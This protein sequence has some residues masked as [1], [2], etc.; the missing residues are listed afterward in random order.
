MTGGLRNV[1]THEKFRTSSAQLLAAE[2]AALPYVASSIMLPDLHMKPGMEAPS[3]FVVATRGRIIPQ[4]VSESIN[5]GMG[6]LVFDVAADDVDPASLQAILESI[7]RAGAVTKLK[8]T[9]YSWTPALLEAACRQGAAPLIDHYGL[10]AE[11]IDRIEDRGRAKPDDISRAAFEAAVPSFLRK[12]KLTRSEIGLNF[13][14]N[15]F[16][17]L[18]RVDGVVDLGA[19][20][21]VGVV[22]GKL[23]VMYHL[24]PGPLGS[25][26]SNLYAYRSKPQLHRK[27]GY[28]AFRQILHASKGWASYRQFAGVGSWMAVDADSEQGLA[29]AG[30]LDVIKNYGFAYRMATV[31]AIVDAVGSVLGVAQNDANLVIDLSHNML[32]SE[33]VGSETL[34]VSRHNCCRPVPGGL[35]IVSGN[36][37]ASSALTISP[38]DSAG[39]LGGFDHGVGFL[40]EEATTAGLTQEDV[41]GYETSRYYMTRGVDGVHR[42]DVQ[43]LL[44]RSV[45]DSAMSTLE[46]ERFASPVAYLRPLMTLKHKA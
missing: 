23:A 3:S 1:T 28:G 10:P 34:W 33:H 19:A 4:L 42:H 16:L 29:L 30:V 41:R 11:W 46:A 26:L 38:Q 32:Q 20:G 43:P 18:Q 2:I 15:H 39:K 22:D 12:T 7:N 13:G 17:E 31:K 27:L 8:P 14:G 44:D 35:G 37:Q 6:L 36:H 5:D 9:R 40:L 45:L 21:P 25:M 24:G